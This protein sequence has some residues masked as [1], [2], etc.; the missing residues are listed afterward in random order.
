M[1]AR[2]YGRVVG[3]DRDEPLDE[4]RH[5]WGSAY[6]IEHPGPDVWIAQRKDSR[7]TL[8]A[9]SSGELLDLIRNDY[10]AH[11]VSRRTAGADRPQARCCRFLPEG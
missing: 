5:H 4:L 8:R 3:S 7:E 2:Y 10:A 11:P 6:V 9:D 1:V